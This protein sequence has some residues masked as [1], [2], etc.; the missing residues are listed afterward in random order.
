MTA[1]RVPLYQK[2][3]NNLFN[4]CGVF[5]ASS[6]R[7]LGVCYRSVPCFLRVFKATVISDV[8]DASERSSDISDDGLIVSELLAGLVSNSSSSENHAAADVNIRTKKACREAVQRLLR[9]V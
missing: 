6:D 7:G 5:S 3:Y 9:D 8:V 4:C 2:C 1:I